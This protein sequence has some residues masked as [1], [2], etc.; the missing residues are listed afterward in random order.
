MYQ[1]DTKESIVEKFFII[2]YLY[3]ERLG[4]GVMYGFNVPPVCALL[5]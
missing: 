1:G 5:V 2:K 3:L 4:S